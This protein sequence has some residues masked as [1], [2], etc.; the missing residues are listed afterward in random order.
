MPL[1]APPALPTD[2]S[3][4]SFQD[5]HLGPPSTTFE[6]FDRVNFVNFDLDAYSTSFGVQP[7]DLYAIFSLFTSS[8]IAAT[9]HTSVPHHLAT[10]LII[11]P[12]TTS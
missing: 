1:D 11:W 9:D 5:D 8:F 12:P 2:P 7:D 3:L 6:G 4:P 10:T